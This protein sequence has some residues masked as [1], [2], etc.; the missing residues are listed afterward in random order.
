LTALDPIEVHERA[1]PRRGRQT[2]R[3]LPRKLSGEWEKL[4]ERYLPVTAEG[5]IWRY[6]R[7]SGP[8]DREQGWKLHVSSNI[9]NANAVLGAVAPFL[10]ECGLMFKAPRSLIELEKINTGLFYGYSQVGKFITV[11]THSDGKAAM[12]A[13]RLH[14]LTEGMCAPAVPFDLQYRPGSCVYY[15]YGAF[16]VAEIENA[17]GTRTLA[18]KDSHGNL[19]PDDR[20]VAK[21]D[22]VTDPLASRRTAAARAAVLSPLQTRFRVFSALTQRGKGGVYKALDLNTDL[23]RFCIVKEGRRSGELQWDGRD[24][25]WRVMHEERVLNSLRAAGVAVPRVYSSFEAKGNHYLVTEFIEGETLQSLL[26][27][28]RRRLSISQVLRHGVRLAGLLARIHAAG[29]VWR[30]CKPANIVVTTAGE[31]RPLDFEG[32]CPVSHPDPVPWATPPFTPPEI[33]TG[34]RRRPGVG[35][36]LYALGVVIYLLLTGDLPKGPTPTP[37]H[38]LKRNVPTSV[39]CLVSVLMET[40][41]RRRPAAAEVTRALTEAAAAVRPRAVVSGCES[42]VRRGG[43]QE[44]EP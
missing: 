14:L 3:A 22:W 31:L 6:S 21:P 10:R 32:A 16:R 8:G 43:R 7:P 28:R 30:D 44:A 33:K 9:L 29:W 27:A 38:R 40:D 20:T 42:L 24:G 37:V 26:A 25:R 5:S 19:T 4:C 11:Y 23:P 15:R 18:L 17:D 12:V 2:S 39:S 1:S 41:P 34:G 35:D 13:R 36:D